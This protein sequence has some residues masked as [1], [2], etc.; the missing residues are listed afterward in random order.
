MGVITHLF[1]GI[2]V[3]D[4]DAG[5]DWYKRFFGRSPDVRVGKEVLWEI[6]EHATLFIEPNAEQ[7]GAGRITLAVAGL[8]GLLDR[9]ASEGIEHEPIETYSNG[10]RHVNVRDPDGNVIA[11]AEPPDA[12]SASP[13]GRNRGFVVD[14]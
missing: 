7:A 10:V 13:I 5:I 2:P 6:D 12:A 11:F 8:D 3:S 1:A 14:C 9:L 4:L